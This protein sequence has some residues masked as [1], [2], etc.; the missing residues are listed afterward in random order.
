[1]TNQEI[2]ALDEQ[3]VLPTYAHIRR[4]A[5]IISGRGATVTDAD[6][7]NYIDFGSGIGVSSLGHGDEGWLAAVTAQLNNIAHVSNYYPSQPAA[8]LAQ[9]LC[10]KSGM[11][12]VFFSNSGAEANEGA[13]KLARKY[14]ADKYG[15]NRATIVTLNGS[16]HGRTVTT[17]AATGQ[18][19]FHEHFHPFTPGFVHVEPNDVAALE[20]ALTADVCAVMI[21]L[22]QG[23][24]GV[25]PLEKNYVS[26]LQKLCAAR[27]ILLI[28]D[29]VQTGIGRTG[30]VFACEH[31]AL[32]PDV[33]TLA[34]GLGGGLPIGAV[35]CAEPVAGVLGKGHHG[36]TYGGNPA[37][38]AG[39]NEVLSRVS[40]A[41]FLAE[42]ERK[43]KF[44]CDKLSKM[45]NVEN[46]RGMGL[47][48][49]FD[50][51]DGDAKKIAAA[52]FDAGL[53]ILTAGANAL[54]LLPPL[55]ISDEELEKGIEILCNIMNKM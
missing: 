55:T 32:T 9:K 15:A 22:I 34:K 50:P 42:V 16:F 26:A 12:K 52:S 6:G 51:V 29:E 37:V 13:I 19:V 33:L 41:G 8:L 43:N 25:Y 4:G 35:L 11:K 30:K 24:G 2:I 10:E 39:A 54:R 36:S 46:I 1:M 14:S 23:E 3:H 28:C 17:L 27:D 44:I 20:N 40:G 31:F 48:I 53:L 5:A 47:M 18:A 7:K 38:C 21:E 49:G 45:K